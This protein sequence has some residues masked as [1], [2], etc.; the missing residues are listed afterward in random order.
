MQ[1]DNHITDLEQQIENINTTIDSTKK[2]I[3][4]LET[5]KKVLTMELEYERSA[6][7]DTDILPPEIKILNIY[8]P[9]K[10]HIIRYLNYPSDSFVVGYD[11]HKFTMWGRVDMDYPYIFEINKLKIQ[12]DSKPAL[13][14]QIYYSNQTDENIM[15]DLST[16]ICN[17][18]EALGAKWMDD[19]AFGIAIFYYWVDIFNN[20]QH[21]KYNELYKLFIK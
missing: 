16:A 9:K 19:M 18:K 20:K 11:N 4:E 15:N 21:D 5:E 17:A 12:L 3:H 6:Y 14:A 13:H 1:S 7:Y 10:Y 8:I 2:Y